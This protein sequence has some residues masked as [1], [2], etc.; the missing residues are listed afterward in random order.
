MNVWQDPGL[1]EAVWSHVRT[2]RWF[3]GKGRRAHLESLVPLDPVI[4]DPVTVRH[5]VAE[6]VYDDA[7]PERYQLLVSQRRVDELDGGTEGPR[8]IASTEDGTALLDATTDPAALLAWAGAVAGTRSCAA[9]RSDSAEA[10]A[11]GSR[12]CTV[13]TFVP[14]PGPLA[15]A[16]PFGGEQSNT[17]VEVD[18]RIIVKL[19][20]RLE[21]GENLDIE[22]HHALNRAG[23]DAV[24]TCHGALRCRLPGQD[25][26]CDL[27][28]V[29]Q[30]LPEPVDGWQLVSGMAARGEDATGEARALGEALAEIHSALAQAFGTGSVDGTTVADQMTARL[31]RAVAQVPA[32]ARHRDALA[33]TFSRLAGRGLTVQ[34]IH[35]DFHLGQTLSTPL[36][37]RII[38]FEGEP[39]KSLA[40]RRRP[41]SVWRDVAGMTRSLS[42]AT[43]AAAHPT[44]EATVAWAR[45]AREAFLSGYGDG[46]GADRDLL[47]AYEA[48]K[49]VYE[50]VYETLNRPDWVGIPLSALAELTS[51]Q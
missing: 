6:V 33:A 51:G 9:P 45:R 14:V 26:A 31:D 23:V 22:I 49:A 10:G 35:G 18:D 19:F 20:R 46:G 43:S 30:R 29:V 15:H 4:T 8:V 24:A 34:R 11:E 38:D 44:D 27:A 21:P 39:L 32:L 13:E 48:D 2:A 50:V 47:T 40:E 3:A 25:E 1:R 12:R 36:G 41:D 16:R 7:G 28:M 37:W 17:S 5:V 42:Y